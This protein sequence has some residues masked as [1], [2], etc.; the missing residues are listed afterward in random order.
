MDSG[1]AP[2]KARPGMTGWQ[3]H[4]THIPTSAMADTSDR[5]ALIAIR[6]RWSMRRTSGAGRAAPEFTI[7]HT[8][9]Q[10]QKMLKT[11]SALASASTT[12]FGISPASTL[13]APAPLASENSPVL[14]Q[15]L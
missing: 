11:I 4:A 8:A 6:M 12:Q 13:L 2:E 7:R 10:K 15:A 14:I 5:K 1:L 3:P 9:A